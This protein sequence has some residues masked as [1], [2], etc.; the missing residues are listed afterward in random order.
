MS[1]SSSNTLVSGA[2]IDAALGEAAANPAAI[3]SLDAGATTP[4]V[5]V[6][7][8]A[9]PRPHALAA[10]APARGGGATSSP[11]TSDAPDVAGVDYGEHGFI[12]RSIDLVLWLVNR[13]FQF[14]TPNVRRL[15]GFAA[16]VTIGM[17]SLALYLLPKLL[18][19]RDTISVF[20]Q[21]IADAR[22]GGPAAT[23]HA[24]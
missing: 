16:L 5:P 11:P 15:V 10:E 3:P 13:P 1:S 6:P 23:P 17:S 19:P 18:P 4:V 21:Q 22:A 7:V 24:P 14:A 8:E 2:E 9:A 12:Y 20:R